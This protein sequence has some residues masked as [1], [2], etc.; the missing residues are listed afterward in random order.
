MSHKD[1]RAMLDARLN[2]EAESTDTEY[3]SS[4]TNSVENKRPEVSYSSR[5]INNSADEDILKIITSAGKR[6][7]G[8]SKSD[9]ITMGKIIDY[10]I[11]VKGSDIHLITGSKPAVRS[12][13][14]LKDIPDT[15]I[16]TAEVIHNL[17][18][19][20]LSE[21]QMSVLYDVGEVDLSTFIPGKTAI[22]I[23]AFKQQNNI[24]MAL[25][26][27]S[28]KIPKFSSLNLP[29]VIEQFSHL[30][31]G[32]VLVTGATGSGK[33]TTLASLVDMINEKDKKHIITVE[34]PIEYVHNHKSCKVNQ[35][36]V[37][38]DTESFSSAL[39]ACLREDPDI[40]LVG[41]MRD[42]E[43]ISI[44]LSAAETGHLVF[45]TLHTVGAAKTIDRIVDSFPAENQNQIRSQLSTVLKGVVSQEMMP[46]VGGGVAVACEIMVA[47]P[48]IRNLIREGKPHQIDSII[49]TSLSA[50]MISLDMSLAELVKNNLI[51]KE[52]AL[53]R[54]QDESFL[55]SLIGR[56]G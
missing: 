15:E 44:A 4:L 56:K 31:K 23:N 3:E 51:D 52:V 35:R 34:D 53:E 30:H 29:P 46:K 39:R 48:A 42:P 45:S 10:A 2:N 50:G 20:L 55:L 11:G 49:Q 27:I 41:E 13:K 36:Q 43:T 6:N 22:R 28:D 37:G 26:L 1:W 17:A 5:E 16:L 24:S 8:S 14:A 47:T 19:S 32:L 9:G 21:K 38:S 25:R 7:E 12:S 33:S 18:A 54:A 40:I